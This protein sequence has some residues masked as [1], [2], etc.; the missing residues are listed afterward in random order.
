LAT[1]SVPSISLRKK[2]NGPAKEGPCHLIAS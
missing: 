1:S 2:A